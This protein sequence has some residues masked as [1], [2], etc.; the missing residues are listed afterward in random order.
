MDDIDWI[1]QLRR[2]IME[3]CI[4]LLIEKKACYG[5]EIVSNLEK[6]N[7][8]SITEGTLYPLLKRLQ[9]E[10]KLEAYWSES[11]NGPPRKY[12]K[13]TASGIKVLNDMSST[14]NELT[15]EINL[16]MCQEEKKNG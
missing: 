4:L 12:Y 16:L 8:L 5:Y 9:K 10:K 11:E 1:V 14:W 3:F 15:K 6:L 7:Y 13:L 2:G